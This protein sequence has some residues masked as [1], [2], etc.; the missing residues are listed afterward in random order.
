VSGK[1]VFGA[2]TG[3]RIEGAE[4]AGASDGHCIGGLGAGAAELD[5]VT[6][7]SGREGTAK[8]ASGRRS[9]TVETKVKG[10]IGNGVSDSG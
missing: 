9:R 10:L 6:R 4:T 3:R 8:T 2:K 5:F 1:V 7:R